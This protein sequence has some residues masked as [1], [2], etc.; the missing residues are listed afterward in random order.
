MSFNNWE[1]AN[2]CGPFIVVWFE[3]VVSSYDTMEALLD[4][5]VDRRVR[6]VEENGNVQLFRR[7]WL[8]GWHRERA[9]APL[10]IVDRLGREWPHAVVAR[11]YRAHVQGTHERRLQNPGF[12]TH[13]VPGVRK[14]RGGRSH[15]RHPKTTAQLRARAGRLKDELEPSFRG[16]RREV[17]TV[18]DDNF[19]R[20]QRSWKSQR[21]HQWKAS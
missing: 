21:R 4:D 14:S 15:Y 16:G 11:W 5:F 13:P 2:R 17:P 10:V 8:W 6:C 3:H 19:A 1:S 9:D 7:T 20:P 12:R 18:Y